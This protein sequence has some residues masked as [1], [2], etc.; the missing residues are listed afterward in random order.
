MELYELET[1][2][3]SDPLPPGLTNPLHP[4][5]T[6]DRWFVDPEELPLDDGS[7]G[8]WR[9]GRKYPISVI[10]NCLGRGVLDGR[11]LLAV[12]T[13]LFRSGSRW[14]RQPVESHSPCLAISFET[15][16]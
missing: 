6:R 13:R 16:N 5:V 15:Y 1:V 12:L 3:T 9:F 14:R 4:I 10:L 11:E 7:L 2:D 8:K